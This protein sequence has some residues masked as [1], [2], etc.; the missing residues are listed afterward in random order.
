MNEISPRT[1]SVTLT[2]RKVLNA[3]KQAA[4]YLLLTV[5]SLPKRRIGRY[6]NQ[7]DKLNTPKL[8]SLVCCSLD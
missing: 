7:G 6:I 3:P 8:N 2:P 5:A 4:D 1:P